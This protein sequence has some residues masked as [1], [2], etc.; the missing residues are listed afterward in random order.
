MQD[1][2]EALTGGLAEEMRQ[3]RLGD[4]RLSQRL[5]TIIEAAIQQPDASFPVMMCNRAALT[6]LYRFMNHEEVTPEAILAPHRASTVQRAS[7]Y[8]RLLLVHDTTE[9]SYAQRQVVPEGMGLLKGKGA[10]F[11]AHFTLALAPDP[12][13][14]PLGVVYL[15]TVNRTGERKGRRSARAALNDPTREFLRWCRS[16]QATSEQFAGHE[17]V[18]VCDREGDGYELMDL[19]AKRGDDFIIRILHDRQLISDD[20][21]S[22]ETPL[23]LFEQ[24]S[25]FEVLAQREVRLSR[26]QRPQQPRARKL[27]PER[28]PRQAKLRIR[29]GRV[30]LQR[31]SHGPASWSAQLTVHVVHV[32][33][34]DA[35]AGVEPVD[36]KLLTTLPIGSAEEVLS[37]V[38]GYRQRWVIEEFFK[39]LKTGCAFTSRQFESLHALQN[40]LATLAPVAW[41]LL[42]L[43][44]FGRAQPHLPAQVVLTPTEL[45]VLGKAGR[46]ALSHAPTL[47]EALYAVAALGGHLRDNGPPGWL[48]LARG[49]ETL[50]LLVRGW[51][52][53]SGSEM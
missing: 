25:D 2:L 18:H 9:F 13:G 52:A 47:E 7:S 44:D 38:D 24:L 11:L 10:G 43:R 51:V 4:K 39:A 30:V 19:I 42:L 21:E 8:M 1:V 45:L 23:K 53:H 16:V 5:G 29:A 49:L 32:R 3:A 37:V 36:W 35:P 31:P 26:R 14:L 15:E 48:T 17:V 40:A 27:H 46:V 28:E 34:V 20:T 50:Q 6:G 12:D 22:D 33:E 41:R